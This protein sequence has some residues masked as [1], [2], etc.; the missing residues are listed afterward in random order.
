MQY[1]SHNYIQY[2]QQESTSASLHQQVSDNEVMKEFCSTLMKEL[3]VTS[4]VIQKDRVEI[5]NLAQ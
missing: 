5:Q 1:S 4:I 2:I 3:F